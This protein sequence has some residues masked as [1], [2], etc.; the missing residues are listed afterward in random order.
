MKPGKWIYTCSFFLVLCFTAHAGSPVW[1]VSKG[2]SHLYLGG[3][4]HIL[5]QKDYPLPPSFDLAYDRADLLVFET[6]IGKSRNPEFASTFMARMVYSDNRTLKNLL[7]PETFRELEQ[8]TALRGI[9]IEDINRFKPGLVLITLTMAE[10]SRLGLGGKGVDEFY[11]DK[12][13]GQGKPMLFLETLS[14]QLAFFETMGQGREDTMVAYIMED[15][16]KLPALLPKMKETWRTGD[17]EGLYAVT[18]EPLKKEFPD[19]YQ[20]MM[21]RRNNAWMP[22]ILT[23]ARTPATEL[24]LVG[25]A[26]LAGDHGIISQLKACGF[27]LTNQ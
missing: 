7:T 22:K 19:I 18:L 4:I 10:V 16:Q 9:A 27:T 24:I 15:I 2:K 8:F 14:Q 23:M 12:G 6:D 5:G 26:H 20:E 17:N 11:F 21:V 25:A 3:T 1:K 13:A